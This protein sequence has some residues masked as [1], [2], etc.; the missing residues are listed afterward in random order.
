MFGFLIGTLSLVGLVKLWRHGPHGFHHG[1]GGGPRRWMLRHL[2]ERLDTTPGQE[3]VILEALGEVEKK[4]QAA[5]E[6]LFSARG[7]FAKAM[8]GEHF[9]SA[10]VDEAFARQQ[11]ALDE[12]KKAARE[13]LAKIHEALTPE[14][15]AHAAQLIE[16]GPS[17]GHGCGHRRAA[18]GP[19]GAQPNAVNL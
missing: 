9:D 10:A 17:F 18:C 4:G 11:A 13:G 19:L 14:Q 6:A 15:R 3:K 1:F 12:L 8:R 2:F 16:L 5:R 7:D